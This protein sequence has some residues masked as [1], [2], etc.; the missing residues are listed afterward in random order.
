MVVQCMRGKRHAHVQGWNSLPSH[1]G[2]VIF[3]CAH[4]FGAGY[5]NKINIIHI[6]N[7]LSICLLS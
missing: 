5:G 2:Q 3:G 7:L 1:E 6:Q 4:R